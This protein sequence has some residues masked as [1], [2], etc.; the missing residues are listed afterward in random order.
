MADR[1]AQA[2]VASVVVA[3]RM[4]DYQVGQVVPVDVAQAVSSP[5]LVLCGPVAVAVR[6]AQADYQVAPVVDMALLRVRPAV[7]VA[8]VAPDVRPVL[9]EP[10]AQCAAAAVGVVVAQQHAAE[11]VPLFVSP[12]VEVPHCDPDP[13]PDA[14]HA[15]GTSV[16]W[17][18]PEP[19][20]HASPSPNPDG[21]AAPPA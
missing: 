11:A 16:P 19:R 6:A 18:D 5:D 13:D 2:V 3:A 17:H 10:D 12:A 1:L 14:R 21:T 9:P 8:L 15:P 20:S 4:A 7:A